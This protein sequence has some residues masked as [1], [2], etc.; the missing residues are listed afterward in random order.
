MEQLKK[1]RLCAKLANFAYIAGNPQM[2]GS[3]D[4]LRRLRTLPE[5]LSPFFEGHQVINFNEFYTRSWIHSH[6]HQH[7]FFRSYSYLLHLRKENDVDTIIVGLRG[8][9]NYST[10]TGENFIENGV[11]DGRQPRLS[12]FINWFFDKLAPSNYGLSDFYYDATVIRVPYRKGSVWK[13]YAYWGTLILERTQWA[14]ALFSGSRRVAADWVSRPYEESLAQRQ[15]GHVHL[16]F[17]SLW[18]SQE[19]FAGYNG[20]GDLPNDTRDYGLLQHCKEAIEQAKG[21]NKRTE[22]IVV[23][24]SLGGAVSCFAALDIAEELKKDDNPGNV[25]LLHVTF[26]APPVGTTAFKDYF[27]E[28]MSRHQ[29]L[30]IFHH[31]DI[32]PQCFAF[33]GS[34]WFSRWLGWWSDWSRVGEQKPISKVLSSQNQSDEDATMK[35]KDRL[36]W[37]VVG[38]GTLTFLSFSNLFCVIGGGFWYLWRWKHFRGKENPKTNWR[39]TEGEHD[40]LIT[41]EVGLEYHSL[42]RYID[43]LDDSDVFTVSDGDKGDA[44]AASDQLQCKRRW[45]KFWA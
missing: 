44:P 18:A 35:R 25:S 10:T 14:P 22:I 32:V 37:G 1:I 9:F 33:C 29:S 42:Q 23:G 24:H 11:R 38:L 20:Q 41:K 31:R 6:E 16:G 39:H 17:W 2:R 30:A 12:R 21:K 13:W 36:K 34:K 28:E 8:T 27:D 5:S 4:Q 26:G 3:T 40:R 45:W 7:R 15:Y 43:L 19:G